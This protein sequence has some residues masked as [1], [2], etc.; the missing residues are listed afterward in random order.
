MKATSQNL[1]PP[2]AF[3]G[4]IIKFLTLYIL[5]TFIINTPH[6]TSQ[7]LSLSLELQEEE[8]EEP[9]GEGEE[10]EQEEEECI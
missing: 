7:T 6:S 10:E 2:S 1:I 8:E 9:G 5:V 4:Q 3:K